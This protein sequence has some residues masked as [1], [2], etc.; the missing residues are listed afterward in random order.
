MCIR[1]SA[2]AEGKGSIDTIGFGWNEQGE[3]IPY[4]LSDALKLL[5][6][7]VTIIACGTGGDAFGDAGTRS[8][9]VTPAGGTAFEVRVLERIAAVAM[10]PSYYDVTLHPGAPMPTYQS[11]RATTRSSDPIE[12]VQWTPP[13]TC[14]I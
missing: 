13:N 11:L 7:S 8:L 4:N 9:R 5:G 14:S 2:Y 6:A 1:D 3:L 12:Y 10:Q